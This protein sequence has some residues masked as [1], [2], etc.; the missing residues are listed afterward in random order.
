MTVT[1]VTLWWPLKPLR[2]RCA[3]EP[4]G[5]GNNGQ[6]RVTLDTASSTDTEIHYT[7]S[8]SANDGAVANQDFTPLSGSVIIPAGA[9]EAF[10]DV[11]VLDDDVLEGDETVIVTLDSIANGHED[12][13]IDGPNSSAQVTISDNDSDAGDALVAIEAT[14]SDASEP[15]GQGNNGQFRVTLGTAS[16]TDT[17]IHYTVSGSANDGA[18]ANQDFTPLSGSVIIPAGATEAF[19]DVSV[20]DDDVLEGDE[21]VIVTLDSIANG[22]EDISIDGPN[23]SAQVTISD[24]DSDGGDALVAI[25]AIDSVA[26]EPGDN[27]QFRVTLDTASSTD[28]EIHYTVSGSANDGAVANQDFTPLSG[29]V[30]IPAGATEAFIDVSVLDDDVLEGDETVIVTLDSIANGHEDI[31]IDGPNNSAQVTISD[32]DSDAGDA[33]VAIEATQSDASEPGGQGNNGQFRVTLGTASSTDTE[34]HYTV[35]GSAN[36]GAVA[37]QDFTPLS[38]SVIIPAGATEAFIDVSVL[39][40]DVLEGDETVIVTLDSIANGHEDISIDGP[41]S[42]A[43]VTISDNDSDAGDALVAIEAIDSVAAEPG[44]NGQFR[45]T[46][47]TASSTDTEIHYTVSGSANDGAVANQDFTPLSGSVIIPAGATEAFID[48]SVL[49]DDVLEGDETVIVT[50]DSIANGHEDISIDGP[51][52]SAQVTISDNDSDGGDALVAIEATQSDA[53]EPG[54]QGNNGQF[55]VTLG[56]AS[57]TDTEIHYTVSGSANDGAVANQDF[58]PLSGSVIIPA[59][60]TEAFIDVSVLDDDVLEG[61]ETV[62][63]TLDSIANG[64]EDISIDGPNSSAQVTISDNDSDGGDALVAIEAID[65]VAAEPGDNGQF[66]VT[67][68]TASSTDTEIHYTVSGSAN[69]GAVANQD[70]TPL[71]GSVIIPA[72]ATEAFIDVSVLDDDV[73]EGDETVIVTLDSIANGHEDIS[74]DGPNSSAEV[75]ISDNDSD[76]GD[77]LVAIEATQSDA[78]EPGGQGNNGQFRVT[79]GTASSTDTE[80]HYTVSGSANDGAV[81]NQDFTP[82][83]GSVIIPAGATEAFIDVSVL[84]DDVLEGDETVIVTLDSIANGHEDISIDGP[85]SSAEVTIS[86]NDSD[87]GDALVAIEAIDSVAA[88]PGDNGQF[89]VTLDTASSTD[90]EIHYTV[91]GSANDGAVANQ[92]FTPLSGSVIIPAGATEAFIDVSV[93]DDDVLEGDETVIVTLDSI[94]NGHEDISIDGP[95]SSAEVTISDNDSDAGDALVAIEATQS[96]ASEPGGQGNNGQFRVTLGTASSTDT[97][98]HYTVSGSANDGAV[99][100]QDFTPLSGSVII[101]AGATEAFIDVSVLDDDVLEGDETVIVTLDSIANGHEDISIDGPNSSAEVTISDND[102]DAGDALVAIEAIDSV[103]AEPGDNGQFRVTLDT[104]SSSLHRHRDPLHRQRQR[105]RRCGGQS[106]LYATEWQRQSDHSG[107]CHRSLYRRQCTT[108]WQR[109][110]SGRCHRSLYRRQCTGRRCAGRG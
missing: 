74:I 4:G 28:T 25:E 61:D 95:N 67:L 33:L 69:D 23:S 22:H 110:H 51:N 7:V 44:D 47:G 98:I 94:A 39:D 6:F 16:S 30:I 86:D 65:S 63:V 35:S 34:I 64:H 40:D 59:G 12:I 41:N 87:A 43:E 109:D 102:S 76:A 90:T 42:S 54:G 46:L 5:Q 58:T 50:L 107:R 80:I 83:S 15:G 106:G 72:G 70:F 48:V 11:S 96:D 77:A 45:V 62:I 89:R 82:L 81:A 75:T 103:A 9:T 19:I 29:S 18:V 68:D 71:S 36:D 85:N 27:G 55:R 78:S 53:S 73:L 105:Q 91:S 3:A 13:S 66:R 8:G 84:D 79:L 101:P 99:A 57:S 10:I 38:G 32:N 20:L 93:L 17:E 1:P 37:N 104:A 92:D 14:Q 88:E 21:T 31:S 56:T 49:D 24:N 52:S 97:E 26:A 100:N 108:E 2:L 60:A